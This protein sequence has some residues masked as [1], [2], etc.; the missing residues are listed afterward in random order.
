MASSS[1]SCRSL[2]SLF[3][4]R[5]FFDSSICRCL[6]SSRSV[7]FCRAASSFRRS[8]AFG[9]LSRNP[10]IGFLLIGYISLPLTSLNLLEPQCLQVVLFSFTVPSPQS[11]H[12]FAMSRPDQLVP[13]H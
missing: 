1:S 6:S 13:T 5:I 7:S 4:R 3:R 12:H 10:D 8:A 2:S 9:T 11:L